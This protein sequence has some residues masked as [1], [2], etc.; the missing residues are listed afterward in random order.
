MDLNCLGS[1]CAS[2]AVLD[3]G[4]CDEPDARL[5]QADGALR[6]ALFGF[7]VGGDVAGAAGCSGGASLEASGRVAGGGDRVGRVGGGGE[8]T[9]DGLI[10]TAKT[11]RPDD[12]GGFSGWGGR[13]GRDTGSGWCDAVRRY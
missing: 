7:L 10:D 6:R 12:A 2:D 3:G 4:D 13:A 1:W 9:G 8:A 5:F 11:L